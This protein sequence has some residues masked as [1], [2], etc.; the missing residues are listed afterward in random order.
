[1]NT[2]EADP[3]RMQYFNPTVAGAFEALEHLASAVDPV[4]VTEIASATRLTRGTALRVM[5]TLAETGVARDVGGAKYVVGARLMSIALRVNTTST[6]ANVVQPHLEE[7]TRLTE[8]TSH[9][10]VL[11]RDKSL[12][13]SVNDCSNALR[14]ASRP[15]TEAWIHAAATGKAIL[16]S[17]PLDQ[18]KEICSR[19]DYEKLTDNT[20]GSS[21]SML[22]H[23][24]QVGRK[25][26]AMDDEE[27]FIGV[28]CLAAPVPM[29]DAGSNQVGAIGFTAATVRFTKKQIPKF[30]RIIREAA[31]EL[32]RAFQ[33]HHQP[34][35][36]NSTS[37][38]GRAEI[39]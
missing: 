7:L 6:L 21:K 22:E 32:A 20:I 2:T 17:L 12:I 38:G 25:G 5:R 28:R 19:L 35:A 16:A 3:A 27:Y 26:Y 24:E 9:F 30:S 37:S 15:G 4:S 34:P 31:A 14:V 8:E 10:A 29:A 13:V 33:T 36:D 39:S 18:R 1:M 23:L 11:S